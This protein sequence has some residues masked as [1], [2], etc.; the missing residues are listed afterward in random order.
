MRISKSAIRARTRDLPITFS[1]ER[2]SSHG[3]LEIVRHFFELIEL[4]ARVR[5]RLRGLVPDGDYG[6]TRILLALIGLLI[7]GGARVTHLDQ[8]INERR[9]QHRYGYGEYEFLNQ[10]GW[11][12]TLAGD[13]AEQ[14]ERE[15]TA[16]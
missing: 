9:Q 5:D 13:D 3:G 8:Q 7:V 6:F 2:I 10:S 15:L 12:D 1:N 4:R 11:R 14:Y 16:L